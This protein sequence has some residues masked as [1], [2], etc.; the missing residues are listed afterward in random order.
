[1]EV[2]Q[3]AETVADADALAGGSAAAQVSPRQFPG[4]VLILGYIADA[5]AARADAAVH[6]V[7][8]PCAEEIG[9][10]F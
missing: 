8:Q 3:L 2:D 10:S 7:D 4:L 1:M 9:T 5:S 6:H